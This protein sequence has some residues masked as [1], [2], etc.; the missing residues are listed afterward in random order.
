SY[1]MQLGF[2]MIRKPGKL[3]GD[4][5]A[6]GYEKEYGT[7]QLEI[8]ADA[9]EK[10]MRAVIVDDVLATGGT[11]AASVTLLRKA[12]A[13]VAG[14]AVIL[15]LEGLHGRDAVDCPIFSLAKRPA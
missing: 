1:S 7:D 11:M 5:M 10:G 12:G 3:P 9:V 8:Q 4:T 13:Q 2:A 14:A 6:L 15:E